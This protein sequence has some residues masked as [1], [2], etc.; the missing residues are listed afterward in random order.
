[1]RNSLS[2]NLP[3]V[4]SE[5]SVLGATVRA[6]LIAVGHTTTE[7]L[8]HAFTVGEALN[9]AKKLVGYGNWEA[10][11]DAECGLSSRTAR[12]YMRLANHRAVLERNRQHAADLSIRAA[13]RLIGTGA[14]MRKRVPAPALKVASWK[15]AGTEE[16][17]AFVGGILLIEWL[18]VMPASWR[19]ELVDRIDG[20]RASLAKPVITAM[21]RAA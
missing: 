8:A 14:T 19:I 12:A 15:A 7:M 16:R 13:L 11:L 21:R 20:L 3:A 17:A 10:W 18:A 5:L 2:S 4:Q 6:E 9:K 1:M